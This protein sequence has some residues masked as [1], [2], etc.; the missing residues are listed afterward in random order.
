MEKDFE[1]LRNKFV[2]KFDFELGKSYEYNELPQKVKND[3]DVQFGDYYTEY[4]PE[5]YDYIY[6]LL[7]P[8]DLS[9]YLESMFGEYDITDAMDEPYMKRLAKSIVTKGI[10]YPGVGY[11]GNHRA[12]ACYML[13]IPYPYLEMKLKDGLNVDDE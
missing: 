13:N 3:I 2:N 5:D 9:E 6:K 10:D 4:G 12:L 8:E 11:E 7:T 1:S